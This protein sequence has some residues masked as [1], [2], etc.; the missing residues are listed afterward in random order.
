MQENTVI[1]GGSKKLDNAVLED[2]GVL[3]LHAVIRDSAIVRGHAV[4]SRATIADHAVIEGSARV[5]DAIVGG[6]THLTVEY[7][8]KNGHVTDNTHLVYIK[9]RGIGYTVHRTK[10]EAKG[11]SAQIMC[12]DGTKITVNQLKELV[13]QYSEYKVL[14]Y[15]YNQSKQNFDE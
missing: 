4:V 1:K 3:E 12:E 10:S 15:L 7:V 9:I 2:F 13:D 5:K 6:D 14:Q 11:Y 8:G